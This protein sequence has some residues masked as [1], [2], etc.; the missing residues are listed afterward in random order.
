[1]Q[2]R[3]FRGTFDHIKGEKCSEVIDLALIFLHKTLVFTCK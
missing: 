3:L 2:P 1:M